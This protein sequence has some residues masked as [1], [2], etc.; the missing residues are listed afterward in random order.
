MT[1]FKF[2]FIIFFFVYYLYICLF[3]FDWYFTWF[4]INFFFFF[5]S[6]A[7][8]AFGVSVPVVISL[9]SSIRQPSF[10]WVFLLRFKDTE[11]T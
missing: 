8:G 9:F 4:Y 10:P 6:F 5:P 3:T 11:P 2:F 7:A 1:T